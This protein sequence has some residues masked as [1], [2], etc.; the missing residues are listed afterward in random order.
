MGLVKC[1]TITDLFLY[2]TLISSFPVSVLLRMLLPNLKPSCSLSPIKR[3]FLR[4][5][6]RAPFSCLQYIVQPV[7]SNTRRAWKPRLTN[8]LHDTL[9]YLCERTSTL[10]TLGSTVCI[11]QQDLRRLDGTQCADDYDNSYSLC[12][13]QLQYVHQ[14]WIC[15][16]FE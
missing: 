14:T 7:A 1:L 11:V 8:V 10:Q 9:G 3:W 4:P 16:L 15:P 2:L 13:I 6:S 5:A 12:I